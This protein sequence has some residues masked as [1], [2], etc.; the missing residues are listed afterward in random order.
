LSD[1]AEAYLMKARESLAG[2]QSEHEAGR[3]NNA[4]N[5][6]Y[7]A[8]FQAAV[9][10]LVL[11][12]VSKRGVGWAH[13]FVRSEFAGRLIRRRKLYDAGLAPYLDEL[14]KA[15]GS[16]DYDPDMVSRRVSTQSVR[17][18]GRL[19]AAVDGRWSQARL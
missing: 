13:D 3:Y 5:R 6:A 12:G 14:G 19:V 4:A 18:A 1:E 10:A 2:A 16:A 7:Y 17:A 8:A 11:H 9:A 15:R